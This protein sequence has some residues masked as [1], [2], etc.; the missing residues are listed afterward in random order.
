[1]AMPDSQRYPLK[2]SLIKHELDIL[3]K[4][5]FFNCGLPTTLICAFLLH[6]NIKEISEI[7]TFKIKNRQFLS[8]KGLYEG[9]CCKSDIALFAW[10]KV[11]FNKYIYLLNTVPGAANWSI[12]AT[13]SSSRTFSRSSSS[14]ITDPTISSSTS[15]SNS[16]SSPTKFSILS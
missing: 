9:Y 15:F 14:L 12:S 13:W 10:R 8:H 11:P 6:E 5:T 16:S 3:W 1:M 4:R 7:I 2:L